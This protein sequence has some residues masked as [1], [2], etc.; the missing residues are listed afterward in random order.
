MS[1]R[2]QGRKIKG[3]QKWLQIVVNEQPDLINPVLSDLLGLSQAG[4]IHWLSPVE[5]DDYAEYRDRQFLERLGI[6][7]EKP[8]TEF[9]PRNGP[10][11]DGL[12]KTDR[13]D[14]IL[15]EAKAHIPEMVSDP[16]GAKSKTSLTRIHNS[17]EATKQFVGSRSKTDWS[18]NFYQY[19]NRLAHLYLLRE[20][21]SLPAYLVFVYF[22]GDREV[23]GPKSQ[24]EW[25]GAIELMKS[26]LGISKRHALSD[27]ILDVF[28]DVDELGPPPRL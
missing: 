28:V 25:E 17:L 19:T 1:R 4:S 9:W 27:Y 16:T 15:V 13:G 10:Q 2:V 20:Q 11:W 5:K 21:N 8:L 24:A 26:H 7:L 3:S 18:I 22:I 12:A 23:D 14:L 6:T